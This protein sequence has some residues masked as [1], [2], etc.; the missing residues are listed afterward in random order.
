MSPASVI[1]RLPPPPAPVL[2]FA[3][4]MCLIIG[5]ARALD[6]CIYS[7]IALLLTGLI[8]LITLK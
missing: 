7:A 6:G 1:F 4:F 8:G 2:A 5:L 3:F